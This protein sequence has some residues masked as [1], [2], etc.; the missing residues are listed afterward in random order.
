MNYAIA[1]AE[2]ARTAP[3]MDASTRE[4]G[5]LFAAYRR[6]VLSSSEQQGQNVAHKFTQVDF[7][8][9][10]REVLTL[11]RS[12]LVSDVV[13]LDVQLSSGQ[14]DCARERLADVLFRA[15]YEAPLVWASRDVLLKESQRSELL[16]NV[17]T[18][19]ALGFPPSLGLIEVEKIARQKGRLVA[20]GVRGGQ[21]LPD[22]RNW[23]IS[24]VLPAFNEAG[25]IDTVLRQILAKEIPGATIEVCIVESNSSD[26]TREK[27]LAYQDHARVKILLEERP[28]G[29]GR[30]V[31][32]G[33]QQA[34][35]DII[36]IQDADLEYDINDY[37]KL[38]DPIRSY[39]ASFVLGSRHAA[40]ESAWQIRSFEGQQSVAGIMNVGHIFFAW[41][42]NFTFRQRLRDPFTMFKVFRRDAIQSM[43]LEC[44]RFDFDHELVG[45]LVR[46][47]RLPIEIDV[48][49]ISRPFDE[50]KKVSF[51][52]DPPTWIAACAKHRFSQLYLLTLPS[53]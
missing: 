52:R 47:G 4:W 44:N 30:A 11:T 1:K 17:L 13:I 38:I 45:K 9:I 51:F 50:G 12:S 31:R 21:V 18:S 25:T 41:F 43:R 6:A 34:S 19:E 2:T 29:K 33:L 42:L 5:R 27:V 3:L 53:L 15:G 24:V 46:V 10:L 40:G 7:E 49:Y 39:R 16:T 36:I 8:D 28:G 32:A 26:G 35:G 20:I 48:K 23:K 14:Y 37:E 22:E